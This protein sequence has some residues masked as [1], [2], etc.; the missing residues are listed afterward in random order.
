[1]DFPLPIRD[2]NS[3]K[4]QNGRVFVIGGNEHFVGVP[5]LAARGAE[6]SGADLVYLSLPEKN[7]MFLQGTSFNFILYPFKGNNFRAEDIERS[8]EISKTVNT[9]LIGNGMGKLRAS[10]TALIEFLQKVKSEYI[11]IDADALIPEILTVQKNS[12]WILTP[13]AGEFQRV[14][15]LE[16]T[17]ENV[18]KMAHAHHCT[19]IVTGPKDFISGETKDFYVNL[20]GTPQMTVGGTG[21][22]LAGLIAGFV[23]QGMKPFDA[24]KSAAYWW[25]KCG[26]HLAASRFGFSAQEMLEAFPMVVG[27]I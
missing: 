10:K 27:K 17:E 1:M 6:R 5:I 21:D 3:R 15:D 20:T 4:G 19:I 7:E 18:K 13:H 14:F 8:L 9:V 26:E 24:V 25:G 2:P 16:V 12:H 23:S 22:S 11:V